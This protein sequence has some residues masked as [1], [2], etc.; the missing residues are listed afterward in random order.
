MENWKQR[1]EQELKKPL[2]GIEVQLRMA[3]AMRRS[4][5][6]DLPLRD[7]G[8]MIVVYPHGG[9]L[10]TVFIKRTEY[11]G[12]HS[13]QISFPGGIYEAEDGSLENTALRETMEETGTPVTIISVIG[14]LTPLHI[15]VS[16][17]NVHVF[18]GA[19][20]D[21]P[22]FRHDPTEVQYL[23]EASLHELMNTANRKT[24]TMS[25]F[26]KDVLVPYFDIQGNQVW[27]ATAMILSE[28]LE[29]IKRSRF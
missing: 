27:G 17:I 26:G 9:L 11:D 8:V 15:P 29:I 7:G 16:N 25:I 4:Q 28:F 14:K 18:V 6:D 1:L 3:P 5:T 2:P 12:V 10:H 24:R 20:L 13:G 22:V 19:A 21:R 23:I